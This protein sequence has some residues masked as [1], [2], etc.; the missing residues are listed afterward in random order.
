[1]IVLFNVQ[2]STQRIKRMKKQRNMFQAKEQG[3]IRET[4]LNKPEISDLPHW[5]QNNGY[6]GTRQNQESNAW[7][8]RELQHRDRKCQKAPNRE[9]TKVKNTITAL[10]T[11]IERFN[12][13]LLRIFAYIQWDQPVIFCC[14]TIFV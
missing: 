14:Y 3:K 1:M 10:K 6:K 2:K 12:N 11:S 4:D 8:Q 9:I 5:V 13:N 7:T